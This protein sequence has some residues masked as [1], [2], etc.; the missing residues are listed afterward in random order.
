MPPDQTTIPTRSWRRHT[1]HGPCQSHAVSMPHVWRVRSGRSSLISLDSQY[2]SLEE[3][4]GCERL[5]DPQPARNCKG[6]QH[7][8][9]TTE[10]PGCCQES[11]GKSRGCCPKIR[12]ST[13]LVGGKVWPAPLLLHLFRDTDKE[14]QTSGPTIG[15]RDLRF[16][17]LGPWRD[18]EIALSPRVSKSL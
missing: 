10:S 15:T 13:V 14:V 4:S 9:R 3:L 2:L 16:G 8:R 18:V 1:T 5:A 17:R 6:L 7:S 12:T 11:A